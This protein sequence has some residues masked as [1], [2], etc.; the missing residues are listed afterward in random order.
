MRKEEREGERELW[1]IVAIG[2]NEERRERERTMNAPKE[3]IVSSIYLKIPMP[4][5]T[6][7][8]S[9]ISPHC[10]SLFFYTFALFA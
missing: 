4:I 5:N 3:E 10:P 1:L 2:R 8:K 7:Y 9:F 6:H